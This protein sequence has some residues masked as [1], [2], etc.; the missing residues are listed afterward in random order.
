MLAGIL[1]YAFHQPPDVLITASG[2]LM[3][4]RAT[5]DSLVFS[6]DWSEKMARETWAKQAGQGEGTPLWWTM[7]NKPLTC[8]DAGCRYRHGST[9]LALVQRPAALPAAC[10]DADL[11]VAVPPLQP[12]VCPS[13]RWVIDGRA[14]T[15]GGTHAIW[16]D[17]EKPRWQSVSDW[18]GNR[19]WNHLSSLTD[20]QG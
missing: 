5:D 12:D 16:L 20:D 6:Q 10:R 13:A 8:D 7:G 4:G 15:Q 14:L 3:A 19:P 11:V 17:S 18:Q 2:R 1:L 9:L